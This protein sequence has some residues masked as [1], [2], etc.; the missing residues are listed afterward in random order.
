MKRI[1]LNSEFILFEV[2]ENPFEV[3]RTITTDIVLVLN[4][5]FSPD[6]IIVLSHEVIAY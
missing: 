3:P 6:D 5:K 1:K 4:I 2:K